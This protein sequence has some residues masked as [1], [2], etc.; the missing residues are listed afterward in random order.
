MPAPPRVAVIGAG[1]MGHGIAQVFAE[2]GSPVTVYDAE[3]AALESLHTRIQSNL[4]QLGR[5]LAPLDRITACG[6]LEQAVTGTELVIEATFEDVE[7]KQSIFAALDELVPP[8]VILA[9]NT[10]VIPIGEIA[11]RTRRRDRVLGTHWWNPPYLVPL[12]EVVEGADTS[13]VTVHKA[14]ELLQMAGKE[15]VHVRR[16]V[17]GFVGNRLQH[18]LWREAIALVAAGVCDAA[19]VDKVVK[20]SFGLRL[21]VLG[22]LENADLIG[23]DLTL[24]VHE[25]VLPDLDRTAGP[26]PYL[27]QLVS[28]GQLGMKSGQGFRTWTNSEIEATRGRLNAHLA[29]TVPAT[30]DCSSPA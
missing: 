10:S 8:G 18:A 20:R 13:Q 30:D 6:D 15:P 4:G 5:D 27:R 16:D 17:P 7:L 23:L 14:I 2:A 24:A 19:T 22:P 25:Q 28:G 26:S 9:T 3:P 1:L 11:A 29:A 21:P 12:V